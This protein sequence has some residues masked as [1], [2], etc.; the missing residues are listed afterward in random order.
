MAHNEPKQVL[1]WRN[2][3]K[4]TKGHKVRSGKMGAQ[5]AHA[6]MGAILNLSIS[7]NDSELIINIENPAV[8]EWINGRFTKVVLQVDSEEELLNVYHSALQHGLNVKIIQDAGLTEFD[9]VQTYTC[10]AIGPDYPDRIDPV[11]K[12]LRLL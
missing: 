10:L 1:V 5:L 7:H 11:T 12:H 6:S 9:G 3:L 2:D 8:R 4:N